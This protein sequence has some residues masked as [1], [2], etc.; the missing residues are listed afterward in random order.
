[1]HLRA[2]LATCNKLASL[3]RV[4]L[5]F[6]IAGLK[7]PTYFEN[8]LPRKIRKHLVSL[9]QLHLSLTLLT[10]VPRNPF[11]NPIIAQLIVNKLV[12]E[13]VSGDQC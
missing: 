10:L 8:A 5:G 7:K 6:D 12:L 13:R 3:G 4:G 1:M 2:V 11:Q 9:F